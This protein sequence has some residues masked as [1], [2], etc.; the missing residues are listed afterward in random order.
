M[1]PPLPLP[2]PPLLLLVAAYQ[3]LLPR[4]APPAVRLLLPLLLPFLM[5]LL[6]VPPPLHLLLA[7]HA[8]GQRR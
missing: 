5:Q 7:R 8:Q 4:L 6:P 2:L 1:C 3:P